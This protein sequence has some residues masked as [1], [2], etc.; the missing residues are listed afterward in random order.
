MEFKGLKKEYE[1]LEDKILSSLRDVMRSGNFILGKEV[2]ALENK[3]AEYVGVRHCISCANATDG[4]ILALM[5]AGITKED[6]VLVPAFSY[7]A[8]ASCVSILG[9]TPVFVDIDIDTYNISPESLR[10]ALSACEQKGLKC[11]ALITVDLFGLP[12][13]YTEIRKIAKNHDLIVIE[14]GA[15]GFGGSVQEKRACSF[16]DVSVTSFFP[17]KPLGAYGD[18]GAIFTDND[19]YADLL[20]SL[21]SHGRTR[22]NKYDNAIIG[23]NSRLDTIQAA[24]LLEKLDLFS[25]YELN[26]INEIAKQYS[27]EL[28]DYVKVPIVP[29][30]MFSSWAQ[31]TIALENVELRAKMIEELKRLSIP[32]MVYYGKPLHKQIALGDALI[33]VDL[34]NS[35]KASNT[36]LSLPIHPFMEDYEVE[37]VVQAVRFFSSERL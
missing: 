17:V 1:L 35:E 32:T 30:G 27:K 14:D 9:A 37:K 5:A 16:G 24:I 33:V 22:E 13:D 21:R 36:V 25:N 29:E 31:Y 4:L 15:Q 6:Y 34:S 28:C 11:K 12:A 7:I 8:S 10:L 19:N 23:F 26:R 2:L 18:G 3:L 20:W